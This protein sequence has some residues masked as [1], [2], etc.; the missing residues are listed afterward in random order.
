MVQCGIHVVVEKTDSFE[1]SERDHDIDNQEE[2]A[3]EDLEGGDGIN[4]QESKVIPSPPYHLLHHP[5]D[6][7]ISSSTIE[8]WKYYFCGRVIG[9][10][11]SYHNGCQN[12][13]TPRKKHFC[14]V[15]QVY[16]CVLKIFKKTFKFFLLILN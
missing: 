15:L 4:K 6:G 16:F 9:L 10:F 12:T 7:S 14:M 13:S 8:Q 1:G 3:F 2:Y 11:H 5:L